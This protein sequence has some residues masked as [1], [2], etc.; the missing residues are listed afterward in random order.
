[1]GTGYSPVVH[2]L[3]PAIHRLN[4]LLSWPQLSAGRNLVFVVWHRLFIGGHRL[5]T[6]WHR[7]FAVR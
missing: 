1:V 5:F 4:R 3:A 7:L 6:G 2:R